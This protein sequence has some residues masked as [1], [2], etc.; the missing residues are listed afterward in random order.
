MT[1]GARL[2]RLDG[3]AAGQ[4][5]RLVRDFTTIGCHPAT[6][7]RVDPSPDGAIARRHL[8][9][10]RDE[11]GWLVRDLETRA[12]TWLNGVRV[13]TEAR[14]ADG[15]EI[16]LGEHG[17]GFQ[18]VGLADGVATGTTP[19]APLVPPSPPGPPAVTMADRLADPTV[20]RSTRIRRGLTL[21]LLAGLMLA[22]WLGWRAIE[23]P[24]AMS[25]E[26]N[27]LLAR[28]DSLTQSL[29]TA[30]AQE[31]SLMAALA[32]ARLEATHTGDSIRAS[33]NRDRLD[34]LARQVDRLEG[35]REPLL[36]AAAF[37]LDAVT[38]GNADAVGLVLAERANLVTVSGSGFVVE[39]RGDTSFVMTSRHLV[40]DSSGATARR[41]GIVFNG[42]AQNF[43]AT[44][45]RSHP[46]LDLALL[47]VV[48]RG[49]T[50]VVR[51][52]SDGAEAGAPVAT[53]TFPLG[54]DLA[55]SGDWRQTGVAASAFTATVTQADPDRLQLDGYG[56]EGMSGSPLF[57]ADG[58][59]V[60]VIYGG[61]AG[62][63]GRIVFAVPGARV[64]ELLAR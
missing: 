64:R 20:R 7:I 48:V 24:L 6:D 55:A 61:A 18:F 38:T 51:G 19:K 2:A 53:L 17:P 37:D 46:T 29:V 34:V 62:S 16:R 23:A 15:A 40:V 11:H 31:A 3:P 47:R 26:R 33:G 32:A 27:L 25:R 41:L 56:V 57:N 35:R 49:G 36:R 13:Q 21:L 28:L 22:G 8:A 50:P 58:L 44:W 30:Q 4:T 10:I 12:G 14:L 42:S 52:L 5:H 60:G 1:P 9:I 54:L 59:V 63:Q 45:V 39:S 43:E